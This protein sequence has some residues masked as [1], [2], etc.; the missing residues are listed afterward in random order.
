[1]MVV[2]K[3]AETNPAQMHPQAPMTAGPKKVA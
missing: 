1:M 3:T 2:Q